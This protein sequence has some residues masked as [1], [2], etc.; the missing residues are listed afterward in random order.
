MLMDFRWIVVGIK[1]LLEIL[2]NETG[3]LSIK[4]VDSTSKHVD[5][6]PNDTESS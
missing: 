6:F 4:H 1:F 3:M 2:S 5:F